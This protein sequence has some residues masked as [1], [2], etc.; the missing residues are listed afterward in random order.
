MTNIKAR[1]QEYWLQR[2]LIPKGIWLVLLAY[3]LVVFSS[4]M[5]PKI[6]WVEIVMGGG[7]LIGGIMLTGLVIREARQQK[8]A[9]WC[10]ILTASLFFIPFCVGLVRGNTLYDMARDIFPL[11]FLL[12]IPV[13]LVFSVSPAKRA[14]L[15]TLISTVLVLVG[16]CTAITF[17]VGAINLLGSTERMVSMMRGGFG[18]L[19]ASQASQTPLTVQTTH[20]VQEAHEIFENKLRKFF[21]KLYDPAMLFAAIFLSSWGVVL[22]TRSWR[23][24]LPGIIFAGS[25]AFIAYG[26][27]MTGLRAYAALFALGVLVICLTQWKERGFYIRLIPIVLLAGT[28][29]WPQIESALQ[30]LWIKQRI[31]GTNGKFDE[32]MA[33]IETI[34]ATPQTILLGIGW[35]GT[36]ENPIL[37]VASRF[38]HSLLSFSLL[39]SG[40][41][42]I[43]V[44]FSV[45]GLLMSY[46]SKTSDGES[47]GIAQLILLIS[48]IPPL[49]IG[50]LFEPTYKMLSYGIIL[51]LLVLTL[52]VYI[53]PKAL[54][55]GT[56][57]TC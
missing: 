13:L 55:A 27:M 43:L 40:A 3:G 15:R 33:V 39:K 16:I 54:R 24:Y 48:C 26:F 49:V 37:G 11:A 57:T 32:W 9:K 34:A 4:P 12:L 51:A 18:Q 52:P 1:L 50:A 5:P 14:S 22:M 20:E 38:T 25:G 19:E 31:A 42:G 56:A 8:S 21:L 28:F 46:S 7:L 2:H 23:G 30:L 41:A 35:G 10:L 6:T 45:I 17:F 29:F 44:L 36:F 53:K 47:R